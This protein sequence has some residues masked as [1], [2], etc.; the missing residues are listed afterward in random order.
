MKNWKT[1]LSVSLIASNEESNIAKCLESVS[2]IADE[3]ILVHNDCTDNTVDIAQ[4]F[5]AKCFE[6]KWHGHRDQKN[7]AL[8]KTN[9]PWVLCLDA[10]ER[11][12]P[13]L[14]TSIK[15]ILQSDSTNQANGFAF[16]RRSF[17]LG[18]WIRHGDWYPDRKVRL[19]RNGRGTWKG[20]REHDRLDVE[21]TVEKL[22]GDLLHF[23]YP[24]M[25]TFITKIIYFSDLNLQRQLDAKSKWSL[26]HVLFRPIWRFVRGYFFR[27]GFLDGFPG[28]FL[29]VSTSYSTFFKYSKLYENNISKNTVK[30]S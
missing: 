27:L 12:S 29:A 8:K 15:K 13:A 10:D 21:G 26:S 11:L 14:L 16:N 9:K 7:I 4:G 30:P 1:E 5:G 18:R 3:I 6:E 24:S 23:S 25:N 20:S 2:E 28:L 17:F 22:D 19:I